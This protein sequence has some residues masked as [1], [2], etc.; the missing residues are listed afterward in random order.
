[1]IPPLEQY[2]EAQ[3]LTPAMLRAWMESEGWKQIFVERFLGFQEE[4]WQSP[5]S[6][7][8]MRWSEREGV[9]IGVLDL[10]VIHS[11]GLTLQAL[12]RAANPRLRL[13]LPSAE[14]RAAHP[15]FWL[16]VRETDDGRRGFLVKFEGRGDRI[17]MELYSAKGFDTWNPGC[18]YV[19]SDFESWSF[20]P[21]DPA[22]NKI[23]WP[24]DAQGTP[25]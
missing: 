7:Y 13:G 4:R 14:A 24:L 9:H 2:E 5:R 12:L 20:W 6:G 18:S 15:G 3:G 16:A 17:W 25:L 1:M 11:H 21:T 8:A 23:L 10:L 22:G 19:T